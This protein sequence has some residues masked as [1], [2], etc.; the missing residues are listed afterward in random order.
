MLVDSSKFEKGMVA[1]RKE[2]SLAKKAMRET[3][4]P[5]EK[6]EQDIKDLNSAFN[7]GAIS[8]ET[9]RRKLDQLNAGY[10]KAGGGASKFLQIQKGIGAS[11]MNVRNLMGVLAGAAAV[12][13]FGRQVSEMDKIAKAAAKLSVSTEFLTRFQF[14]AA[15]GAGITADQTTAAIEK[16]T[17]QLNKAE[18]QTGRAAL[19]LD[20]YNINLKDL[21]RLS[22]QKTLF[23]VGDALAKITDETERNVIS[24]T[25][26]GETQ[27]GLH[28]LLT[29]TKDIMA[30]LFKQSDELGNTLSTFEAGKVQEAADAIG[31]I[32]TAFRGF[33]REF[34]NTVGPELTQILR[35]LTTIL[36]QLSGGDKPGVAPRVR[37]KPTGGDARSSMFGMVG[38]FA[39]GIINMEDPVAMAA[40]LGTPLQNMER[41]TAQRVEKETALV[42]A[43]QQQTEATKRQTERM[44]DNRNRMPQAIGRIEP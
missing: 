26:F 42:A 22:P 40:N 32:T 19:I 31:E 12:R 16:M 4:T 13:G 2:L 25:I 14:A 5:A 36:V 28:V 7:K 20:K 41:I 21:V 15:Q 8:Q 10:K 27:S 35:E 1:S 23:A 39:A 3:A 24:G 17:I 18:H 30:D 29:Q 44:H 33:S 43:I 34:V 6:L 11:L 9:Y 37:T 38:R